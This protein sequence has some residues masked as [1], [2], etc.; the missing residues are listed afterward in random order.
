MQ[1]LSFLDQQAMPAANQAIGPG[2]NLCQPFRL[3]FLFENGLKRPYN[4]NTT[5]YNISKF[6]FSFLWPSYN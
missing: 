2:L 6:F 4:K 5:I 1:P 3:A